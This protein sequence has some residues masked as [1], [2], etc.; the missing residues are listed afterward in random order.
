MGFESSV[1]WRPVQ[2]SSYTAGQLVAV[3]E[4]YYEN[5]IWKRTVTGNTSQGDYAGPTVSLPAQGALM[6]VRLMRY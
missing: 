5:G 1:E 2:G 4:G 6:R 3:E